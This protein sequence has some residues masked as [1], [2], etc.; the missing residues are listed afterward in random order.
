M[1]IPTGVPALARDANTTGDP[2]SASTSSVTSPTACASLPAEPASTRLG[3][4]V[5]VEYPRKNVGGNAT[6]EVPNRDPDEGVGTMGA[7]EDDIVY[8]NFDK[9]APTHCLSSVEEDV[10]EHLGYLPRI[11]LGEPHVVR[12]IDRNAHHGFGASQSNSVRDELRDGNHAPDRRAALSKSQQ[13]R[14]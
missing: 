2:R 12:N 14:G 9:P 4:E 11:D 6:A 13:L 7:L 8:A 3:S 10:M 1:R 5:W